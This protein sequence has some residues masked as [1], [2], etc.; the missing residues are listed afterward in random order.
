MD[1]L[2]AGSIMRRGITQLT[3]TTIA[4]ACF[5]ISLSA[6]RWAAA[7]DRNAPLVE[8]AV[9]GTAG[10]TAVDPEVLLAWRDWLRAQGFLI[11]R[12][13]SSPATGTIATH[14]DSP[15]QEQTLLDA[16]FK[17][18]GPIG[19]PGLRTQSEYFDP[20]E[21]ES[22]LLQIVSDHPDITRLFVI[23]ATFE[24]RSIFAL[25]ISD[26]PGIAEDE[27]AIQF[28]GQHHAR[29]VATSH[30]VFDVIDTLTDGYGVDP[31]VTGWV[32]AYKTVCVPMVNPDGVQ[33]VFN[34]SSSWR[35]N[36]RDYPIC[37]GVDLNRNYPYLWGPGCGSSG[38]CNDLYR[39][40]S[41]AS[42]LETQAM[43]ALADEFH[44]VMATSYHAFGRFIDYPYACSD[45]SP[46]GIMPEH[47]VID[48]M[49]HDVADAI[50]A[51]DGINYT[52]FSP[53]PL[54]GVNGDD[55]SWYYAHLGAYPF[56]IEVG[57]SFEPA[58]GLVDGIVNRNR[59]GW[60]YLYDRLG[61]SR[62]DI[63][64]TDACTNAPMEADITLTDFVYDTGE[65][66]RTT[67]LPFG[68]W[69]FVVVAQDS[70]TVRVSHVGY[71]TQ[72]VPV[73]V[74]GEP[75]AVDVQ[76]QPTA[77]CPAIPAASDWG[78]VVMALLML[79]GGTVL[80]RRRAA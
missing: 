44:F 72:D 51:V 41:A 26:N 73:F 37:L 28:N 48:E 52:V 50:F 3:R 65:L 29:E 33:H 22:M 61:Q 17:I 47:D 15:D 78:L 27:P 80:V 59:G 6:Q 55:T 58:F 54:G 74:G 38:S 40:P 4:I 11:D 45:G 20:G 69:T 42:E 1:R 24:G 23:G 2:K 16:G 70:Y 9:P 76:L 18:L 63:H 77:E 39:G 43:L 68:R 5:S 56:I 13:G 46:S 64:V 10:A 60:Q 19:L 49:M 36:R 21:I 57:T 75:V 71:E 7:D 53:V 35:K 79:A 12:C 34:G 31:T 25:E 67:F 32:D 14:I 62:I 8:L 66:A 30:V